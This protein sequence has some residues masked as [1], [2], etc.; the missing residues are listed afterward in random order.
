MRWLF[1]V[2]VLTNLVMAYWFHSTAAFRAEQVGGVK[3]RSA[4][5]E[6]EKY[7]PLLLV[8][9]VRTSA[10]EAPKLEPVSGN[11]LASATGD[12]SSL[13]D[14][15]EPLCVL[16]GPLNDIDA[17]EFRRRLASYGFGGELVWRT[18]TIREDHWLIIP[19]LASQVEAGR[20]LE[21]LRNK[22]IDS[23]LITDGEYKDGITLGVFSDKGNIEHYR[24]K[25]IDQGYPVVIVPRPRTQ[26]ARWLQ[27]RQH[28]AQ[29]TSARLIQ[30]LD[31]Q[32]HHAIVRQV[33]SGGCIGLVVE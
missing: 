3:D 7:D 26:E 2:L 14:G 8:T 13:D 21:D 17:E 4:Y 18:A 25:M 22:K 23:F 6:N 1:F 29:S 9:E 12:T 15:G 24:R 5:Q 33:V 20:M 32:G 28:S 27:L 19:P 16:I 11:T 31:E 10:K 30:L